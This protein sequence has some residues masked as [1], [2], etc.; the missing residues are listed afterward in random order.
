MEV[1]EVS[2]DLNLHGTSCRKERIFCVNCEDSLAYLCE[3]WWQFGLWN[4]QI[5][6][7]LNNLSSAEVMSFIS[8][9]EFEAFFD[10]GKSF[11][12]YKNSVVDLVCWK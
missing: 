1:R 6:E 10:A 9:T 8:V 4:I 5:P 3:L 2:N 12:I 11:D 7:G